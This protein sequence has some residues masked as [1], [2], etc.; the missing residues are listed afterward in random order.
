M[1]QALVWVVLLVLLPIVTYV[2]VY[3][4]SQRSYYQKRY[5]R[6]L[7][8][9]GD[10]L[11]KDVNNIPSVL[12]MLFDI[13]A[14]QGLLT[15]LE[16]AGR[17]RSRYE[18]LRERYRESEERRR[19]LQDQLT[20]VR[21]RDAR[22]KVDIEERIAARKEQTI[23]FR[24]EVAGE[25]RQSFGE[26]QKALDDE[27]HRLEQALAPHQDI[28]AA[29]G[30]AEG[31]WRAAQHALNLVSGAAASDCPPPQASRTPGGF[32]DLTCLRAD[33]DGRLHEALERAVRAADLASI[34]SG[35]QARIEPFAPLTDCPERPSFSLERRGGRS[36]LVVT[37]C[38]LEALEGLPAGI[39]MTAR[40]PVSELMA[41]KDSIP[42]IEALLL[43]DSRG[44][45]LSQ[46]SEEL[47]PMT[48]LQ[49]LEPDQAGGQGEEEGK[50]SGSIAGLGRLLGRAAP[51]IP[52]VR[53]GGATFLRFDQ[54]VP[55][56]LARKNGEAASTG[57]WRL[58]GLVGQASFEREVGEVPTL[59]LI[60]AMAAILVVLAAL[61]SLRL[62]LLDATQGLERASVTG[63]GLSVAFLVGLVAVLAVHLP[64]LF[65]MHEHLDEGLK[66]T[67]TRLRTQF[68]IEL[69]TSVQQLIDLPAPAPEPEGAAS[70]ADEDP[71]CDASM[72]RESGGGPPPFEVALWL[73]RQ[74]KPLPGRMGAS[75]EVR[76]SHL[77]ATHMCSKP[78]RPPPLGIRRYV[79]AAR[80]GKLWVLR[81]GE[82]DDRLFYADRILSLRDGV[83]QTAISAGFTL[84]AAL[85]PGQVSSDGEAG[86]GAEQKDESRAC[87]G[88]KAFFKRFS[89]FA[90]SVMGPGTGF[91]VVE[92]DS[93]RVLY[94]SDDRASLV[95]DF[96]AD[97]DQ[98]RGLVSL[99]REGRGGDW[100]GRYRGQRHRFHV[101]PLRDVPWTLVVFGDEGFIEA[102][103]FEGLVVTVVHLVL[104][105]FV[106]GVPLVL[107]GAFSHRSRWAWLWPNPRRAHV[108]PRAALSGA[109]ALAFGAAATVLGGRVF[110][111]SW[112]GVADQLGS[113]QQ[114]VVEFALPA[115]LAAALRVALWP[116]GQA[117]VNRAC[118]AVVAGGL[119]A[120]AVALLLG[121]AEGATAV[122]PGWVATGLAFVLYATSLALLLADELRARFPRIEAGRLGRWLSAPEPWA[123]A[124]AAPAWKRVYATAFG[125]VLAGVSVVP[126]L[127]IYQDALSVQMDRADRMSE[128][129]AV[130]E[131]MERSAR[132]Q[133]YARRF[134]HPGIDSLEKWLEW[135]SQDERKAALLDLQGAE[136][137]PDRQQIAER[138]ARLASC[139]GC[140]PG[141]LSAFGSRVLVQRTTA[142][143][144][145]GV[146]REAR[147]S[148]DDRPAEDVSYDDLLSYAAVHRT[149]LLTSLIP[150]FSVPSEQLH[151]YLP[152][153]DPAERFPNHA[154][155]FSPQEEGGTPEEA[156]PLLVSVS[157][158]HESAAVWSYA[159]PTQLL[160]VGVTVVPLVLLFFGGVSRLCGR[161]FGLDVPE[162]IE[163]AGE[164]L[165][166][167][168]RSILVGSAAWRRH[169]ALARMGDAGCRA[170][171]LDEKQDAQ[172]LVVAITRGLEECMVLTGVDAALADE[173]RRAVLYEVL[174]RLPASARPGLRVCLVSRRNPFTILRGALRLGGLPARPAHALA[175][176]QRLLG[177]WE[178]GRIPGTY[179]LLIR[180][181]S[182]DLW[183]EIEQIKRDDVGDRT[184]QMRVLD[185]STPL[186][187][188]QDVDGVRLL[189]VAALD[190]WLLAPTR[191]AALLDLLERVIAANEK[192]D[193]EGARMAVVLLSAASPMALLTSRSPGDASGNEGQGA[194][195]ESPGRAREG[196]ESE[197]KLRWARVLASFEPVGP[198]IPE[199]RL[200]GTPR[201]A[202]D[203]LA[204]EREAWPELDRIHDAVENSLTASA[205][206]ETTTPREVAARVAEL[207]E[208]H[209]RRQWI[210]CS[211]RERIVLLQLASGRFLNAGEPALLRGLLARGLVC[212]RPELSLAS[213]SFA[214]FVRGAERRERVRAWAREEAQGGSWQ[215]VRAPLMLALV[216]SGGLVIL[217]GGEA[218]QSAIA[219]LSG[220]AAAIPAVLDMFRGRVAVGGGSS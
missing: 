110:G 21:E 105:L 30:E 71:D 78:T 184:R 122:V 155:P 157:A 167:P 46:L 162:E 58:V 111:G 70:A 18:A 19:E 76:R 102:I 139:P 4:G 118:L 181:T 150:P 43:V 161:L 50:D 14:D 104:Y 114:L 5:A 125:L 25:V 83:K 45:V 127:S 172:R 93:G 80:D 49:Q 82:G 168:H 36:Y 174:S 34:Y 153:G 140:I 85:C 205:A 69:A 170:I 141:G 94:H 8:S 74:G 178:I 196:L 100:R 136:S 134:Y 88:V 23:L 171:E 175:A 52:T 108:Y 72:P 67:A 163:P 123:W 187:D 158:S 117:G 132:F 99:V 156:G 142:G 20:A 41:A 68:E 113:I 63:L 189:V 120:M 124:T 17:A 62:R 54:P 97:V 194:G 211:Q 48:S 65:S 115:T 66:E 116:E 201:T 199:A 24:D 220:S 143:S 109:M 6:E 57:D 130:R 145:A 55:I 86:Q 129:L 202:L 152:L 186:G 15:I 213:E 12:R 2:V 198:D 160:L 212:R 106:L 209:Y 47:G 177:S 169:P 11:S 35:M 195:D 131:A 26:L 40:L 16:N 151:A 144:T 179:R 92:R 10:G 147:G 193:D 216:V 121:P 188:L 215:T 22:L 208:S 185:P 59:V 207:A 191:A 101:E 87:R 7:A 75:G 39:S 126:A 210:T 149:A 96:F 148:Q 89:T 3:Q 164:R 200:P 33:L 138:T 32:A 1:G 219:L 42:G 173:K 38:P 218:V 51:V 214:W 103:G 217:A 154:A 197:T 79:Q 203:Q 61:P 98:D 183:R 37:L 112:L 165:A 29:L 95:D 180:Q 146:D 31:E 77:Y 192:K 13:R 137:E 128:E 84:P 28:V 182:I 176:W 166:L 73:D 135:R 53:V 190:A 64:M 159:G 56:T 204:Q 91:A 206:R 27:T 44:R 9:L 90:N 107:L 119:L 60:V 81:K 133:A